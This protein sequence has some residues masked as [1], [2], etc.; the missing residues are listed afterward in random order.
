MKLMAFPVSRS[1]VRLM[2][3]LAH[4][5]VFAYRASPW[6]RGVVMCDTIVSHAS[7]VTEMKLKRRLHDYD[8]SPSKADINIE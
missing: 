1:L 2:M 8:E 7:H 4:I 6:Q 5:C 3:A